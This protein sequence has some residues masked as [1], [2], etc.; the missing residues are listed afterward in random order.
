VSRRSHQIASLRIHP[1]QADLGEGLGG[2]DLDAPPVGRG[3][4]IGVP[5]LA[6]GIAEHR[7]VVGGLGSQA[8]S[9]LDVRKRPLRLP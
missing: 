8:H 6:V 7:L 5:E 1:L 4:R 9:R 3:G 2:V